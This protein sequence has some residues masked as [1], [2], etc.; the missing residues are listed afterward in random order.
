LNKRIDNFI[1]KNPNA[2]VAQ[3]QNEF[4]KITKKIK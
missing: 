4:K 3:V 2:T 1:A